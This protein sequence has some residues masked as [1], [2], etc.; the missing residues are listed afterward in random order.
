[1]GH[2]YSSSYL[3]AAYLKLN[4][5]KKA[6]NLGLS[7][8]TEECDAFEIKTKNSEDFKENQFVT[9]D[10]F[11]NIQPEEDIDCVVSGHNP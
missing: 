2:I 4:N 5:L 8:I 10:V 1:M 3:V 7:G 6:Y 9:Y 11:N